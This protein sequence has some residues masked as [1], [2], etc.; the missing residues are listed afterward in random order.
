M[1]ASGHQPQELHMRPCTK[2]GAMFEPA[3]Y[4]IKARWWNC[5]DCRRIKQQQWSANRPKGRKRQAADYWSRPSTIEKYRLKA[6]IDGYNRWRDPEERRKKNVRR[7]TQRAVQSGRLIKLPCQVCSD[8]ESEAHH[9]DY[10]KPF[11]V[12][13]LCSACHRAEH[14][15]SSAC[16]TPGN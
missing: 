15:R 5:L 16:P 3:P 13:W 8:V 7:R 12:M 6:R 2:C 4:Q 14:M 11:E 9:P 1:I 10:S